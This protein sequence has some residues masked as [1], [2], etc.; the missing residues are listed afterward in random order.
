MTDLKTIEAKIFSSGEEFQRIYE[1]FLENQ[2]QASEVLTGAYTA[3]EHAFHEYMDANDE[4]VFR[5]AYSLGYLA[6]RNAKQ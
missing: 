1:T 5:Y 2:P 6:G 3:M 4:H